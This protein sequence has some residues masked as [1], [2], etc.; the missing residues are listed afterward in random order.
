MA[1]I[2]VQCPDCGREIVVDIKT[3]DA[4]RKENDRLR[5]QLADIKR[6]AKNPFDDFF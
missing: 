2:T 6:T 5:Q 1:R 4:L 3:I